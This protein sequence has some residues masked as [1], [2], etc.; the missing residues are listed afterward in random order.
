M[1]C[2]YRLDDQIHQHVHAVHSQRLMAEFCSG[3]VKEGDRLTSVWNGY[4]LSCYAWRPRDAPRYTYIY[5]G[6]IPEGGFYM[7]R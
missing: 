6:W 2:G 7:I 1:I 3:N 4:V 5:T